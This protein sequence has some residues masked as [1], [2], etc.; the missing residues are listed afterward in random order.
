MALP[1]YSNPSKLFTT[2]RNAARFTPAHPSIYPM[3]QNPA[4][5]PTS[6]DIP[7]S[8]LQRF[9]SISTFEWDKMSHTWKANPIEKRIDYIYSSNAKLLSYRLQ[10]WNGSAWVDD[11]KLI[12]SYDA[13]D[14]L[15]TQTEQ[16]WTGSVWLNGSQNNYMYDTDKNIIQS[17]S[18]S[19]NGTNWQYQDKTTNTFDPF[20]NVSTECYQSWDGSMWLNHYV[21]S[22]LYNSNN[23]KTRE[24]SQIWINT[25][26]DYS[27]DTLLYDAQNNFTSDLFQT[28]NGATWMDESRSTFT[29]DVNQNRAT[30]LDQSWNGIAWID[31]A[32]STYRFDANHNLTR[33]LFQTW[34]G[35]LWLNASE[36]NSTYDVHN[37][38]K[39]NANR[40][41]NST[42]TE[43]NAGDS[44]FFYFHTISNGLNTTSTTINKLLIYPNPFQTETY[45][46]LD[47]AIENGILQWLDIWGREVKLMPFSG[48]EIRLE[49]GTQ[50]EGIYFVQV[51]EKNRVIGRQK[52][53]IQ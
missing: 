36:Y 11:R 32:K 51:L 50:K 20:N 18:L 33:E 17:I 23:H 12:N 13:N 29:Y 43:I 2:H 38:A 15:V 22:F 48:K 4:L 25:W 37:F 34:D 6:F 47:H 27:K 40:Y 14:N 53:I 3:S 21:K 46:I 8:L 39:S 7:E 10:T 28:W 9:D 26:V 45:L 31:W 35:S 49:K 1:Q 16:S 5:Y 44:Q 24:I 52:I 30:A 41:W 19:W 42:G